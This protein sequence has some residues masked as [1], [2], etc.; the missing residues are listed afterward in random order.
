MGYKVELD[1][2]NVGKGVEVYVDGL[3]I[4]ENPG[5]YE[6]SQEE[7]DAFRVV[8]QKVTYN[9]DP[10]NGLVT[11]TDVELGPTLLEYFKGKEGVKVTKTK[12][13]KK[14]ESTPEVPPQTHGG[15]QSE[16]P[17][18]PPADGGGADGSDEKNE[19]GN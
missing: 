8:H 19:G 3:G 15:P 13:T 7:A 17:V 2:P 14:A 18:V 1:L 4:L 6:V 16:S 11:S 12:D 5:T 10:D 9:Q